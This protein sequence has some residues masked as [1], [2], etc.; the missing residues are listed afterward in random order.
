MEA[1]V[2]T[3][4]WDMPSTEPAPDGTALA[5]SAQPA[6]TIPDAMASDVVGELEEVVEEDED[7]E[8]PASVSL[9]PQA[10][11]A[12]A[13]PATAMVSARRGFMMSVLL[14]RLRDGV[15]VTSV[16]RT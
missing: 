1:A 16:L 13:T 9:L 5:Y 2:A 14:L 15:S 11:A 3:G 12:R 4:S 8:E 7:A 6:P 10:V